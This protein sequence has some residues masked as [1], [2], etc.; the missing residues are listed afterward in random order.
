MMLTG[1][2]ILGSAQIRAMEAKAIA[3]GSAT[4]ETL[5]ER[6]GH[7]VV[8]AILA[9]WPELQTTPGRAII[10]CGPGNNGGDG[11]VV[12]RLL[13]K[14]GWDVEVTLMGQREALPPDARRQHDL[15]SAVRPVLSRQ[16]DK[17][18]DL[19][20]DALFGIGLSRPIDTHAPALSSLRRAPRMVAV[21]IPS[22]LCADSG[23]VVGD[24]TLLRAVDLTVTFHRLRPGHL[25]AE[26]PSLCGKVVV[27]DIGLTGSPP[28]PANLLV[29][30]ANLEKRQGHK[31]DH[32][33]A[34]IV[35]GGSAQG[36]AAR[37]SARAALRVGSGLVTLCPTTAALPEHA[38]P[39]DALMKRPVDDAAA[40]RRVLADKRVSAICIGPGCGIERAKAL[41]PAVLETNIPTI[42]DADAITALAARAQPFDDLHSACILTPHAG[43]FARLFP[44][45]LEQLSAPVKQ[46]PAFS[47]LD[48][49]RKAATR[50]GALVLLKGPDTVIAA[51][52]GT[53]LVHSANDL[54]WLATA[55][56]GDVLAGLMVGLAARRFPVLEAAGAAVLVHA[57]A[58]RGFGPGL[59]ADD[60][61]DYIPGV[62]RGLSP[63]SDPPARQVLP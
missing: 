57:L 25:L 17:S 58:A 13:T 28:G 49:V 29:Q 4:G 8:D 42:L 52:D 2:E 44:D 36:G 56:A 31:F 63:P 60:L 7:A 20:I 34:V 38:G 62:L 14:Q 55:G 24:R 26:G 43:E 23:R 59:I 40:L 3:E 5:M 45:L 16:Q 18:A 19:A 12:A 6:A 46:G 10:L 27:A 33:H 37:L 22:G 51:P 47:R 11:F 21:D 35:S 30:G 53:A 15:W 50:A 39:P 1:T 61:P 32:G 54:P 41:L 9:Q 48:A